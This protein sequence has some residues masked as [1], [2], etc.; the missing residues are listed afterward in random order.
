MNT[1]LGLLPQ[2]IREHLDRIGREDEL[3][4]VVMDLGRPPTAR[5]VDGEVIIREAE[6][7]Q[8]GNR[9]GDQQHR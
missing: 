4:E 1:L 3:L 8:A 2:S 7:S 6:I 9:L 5:Y